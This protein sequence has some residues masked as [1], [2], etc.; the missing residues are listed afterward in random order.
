MSN[1]HALTQFLGD[2]ADWALDAPSAVFRVPVCWSGTTLIATPT[3]DPGRVAAC[4]G[5]GQLT[6]YRSEE[7]RGVLA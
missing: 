3:R 4:V 6:V 5:S 1:R 2:L 7:I